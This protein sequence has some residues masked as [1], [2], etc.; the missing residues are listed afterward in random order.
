MDYLEKLN[1]KN[2]MRVGRSILNIGK[3][4]IP[5]ENTVNINVITS[6]ETVSIA[7]ELYLDIVYIVYK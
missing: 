7:K 1:F 3:F 2:E 5:V 6:S 4:A